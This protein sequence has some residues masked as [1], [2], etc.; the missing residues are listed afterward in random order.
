MKITVEHNGS[1]YD[2]VEVS[3][4][5][6]RGVAPEVIGAA[7]KSAAKSEVAKRANS[8]RAR[9]SSAS[10]GKLVAYEIKAEISANAAGADADELALIDREAAARDKSREELL[11][12]ISD[13]AASYRKIALLVEVIEAE[14][15]ASLSA[16]SDADPDIEAKIASIFEAAK[17]EADTEFDAAVAQIQGI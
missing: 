11:S 1:L 14:T 3:S 10:A 16:I 7:L 4:V 6:D 12:I 5:R 8:Y 9:I 13:K 15:N 2:Q 17:A